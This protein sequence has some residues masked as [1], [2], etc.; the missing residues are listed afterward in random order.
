CPFYVDKE[1]FST[2][3]LAPARSWFVLFRVSRSLLARIR[4][5][6]KPHAVR[7]HVFFSTKFAL[8]GK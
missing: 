7:I 8:M 6:E 4:L 2:C 5:E 3:L 1:A